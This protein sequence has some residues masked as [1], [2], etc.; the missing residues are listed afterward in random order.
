MTLAWRK[1][2]KMKEMFKFQTATLTMN[3]HKSDFLNNKL[4]EKEKS[5][6]QFKGEYSRKD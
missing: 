5:I 3:S 1:R 4:E 6:R 2:K